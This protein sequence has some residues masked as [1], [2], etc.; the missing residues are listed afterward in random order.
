MLCTVPGMP[1]LFPR[2]WREGAR[3]EAELLLPEREAW[4]Y[5]APV[6]AIVLLLT[7]QASI[8]I[9]MR[10]LTPKWGPK[11]RPVVVVEIGSFSK[12]RFF[13]LNSSIG[14]VPRGIQVA[15]RNLIYKLTP[16]WA[17]DMQFAWLYKDY[18]PQWAPGAKVV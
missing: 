12:A 6:C 10:R 18:K 17:G 15:M 3:L 1:D 11:Q 16:K 2:V 13:S 4:F 8:C 14:C 5:G 9:M 7:A